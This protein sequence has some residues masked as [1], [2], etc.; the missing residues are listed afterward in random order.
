MKVSLISNISKSEHTDKKHE[1]FLT[2][3]NLEIYPNNIKNTHGDEEA[4]LI[5][6]FLFLFFVLDTEKFT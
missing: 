3:S 6:E 2:W 1:A 5:N 4:F